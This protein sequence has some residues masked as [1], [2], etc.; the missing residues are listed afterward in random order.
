MSKVHSE[1]RRYVGPDFTVEIWEDRQIDDNPG[2][3]ECLPICHHAVLQF[4]TGYHLPVLVEIPYGQQANWLVDYFCLD[5]V[6]EAMDLAVA[7]QEAFKAAIDQTPG[8]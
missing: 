5:C 7:R 6:K 3:I 1:P 2:L 4:G 8:D